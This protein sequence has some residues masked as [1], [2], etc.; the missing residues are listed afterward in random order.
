MTERCLQQLSESVV[1]CETAV[2]P[3]TVSPISFP[4]ANRTDTAAMGRIATILPCYGG[5]MK[6]IAP[7]AMKQWECSLEDY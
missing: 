5:R 2:T 1:V 4:A 3:F 6:L 7:N